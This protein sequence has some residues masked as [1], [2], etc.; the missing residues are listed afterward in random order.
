MRLTTY[1]D[2][3]MRVMIYLGLPR[4]ELSTIAGIAKAYDISENH[5]TKVV[6]QLAKRGFI[7]TVRGKNGGMRLARRPAEINMGEVLRFTEGESGLLPCVDGQGSCC[8]G[9]VCN[10]IDV[11][12]DAQNAMF[13]VMDKHTL[14]DV[15]RKRRQPL[16]EILI[17]PHAKKSA[18]G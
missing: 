3:A 7:E 5:L 17:H 1:S 12:R 8:I 11:L 14:A 9:G 4:N 15:L 6:H 16:A 10:L 2:Y 13:K 18:R